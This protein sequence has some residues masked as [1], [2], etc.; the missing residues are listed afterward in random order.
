MA[1]VTGT[2]YDYDQWALYGGHEWSAEMIKPIIKE[3]E[4]N[5][6]AFVNDTESFLLYHG[7][8][9]RVNVANRPPSSPDFYEKYYSAVHSVLNLRK[10]SDLNGET[11][12]GVTSLMQFTV[13]TLANGEFKRESSSTA[14]L[15]SDTVS[16]KSGDGFGVNRRKL[17]IH[18]N[19]FATKLVFQNGKVVGI[20]YIKNGEEI[21]ANV[22]ND[23]IV[24]AGALNTPA[25]LMR[26]GIGNCTELS[27]LGIECRVDSASVGKHLQDHTIL[28]IWGRI[29]GNVSDT[30]YAGYK[31]KSAD[32]YTNMTLSS[33]ALEVDSFLMFFGRILFFLPEQ[34]SF[35]WDNTKK[36]FTLA[37]TLLRPR[38]M[39]RLRVPS[40][41][42]LAPPIIDH[43]YL[44][45]PDDFD[46]AYN[47]LRDLLQV[48]HELHEID[49]SVE[50]AYPTPD[51]LTDQ[52]RNKTIRNLATTLY[53]HSGTVR[54]GEALDGNLCVKGIGGLRVADAS[55]M[56]IVTSANTNAPSMM[57]GRKAADL[58]KKT[59]RCT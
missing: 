32:R 7:T 37:S 31:S 13:Q 11:Q 5:S 42:P 55:I 9:G 54:L 49:P 41:D 22:V 17:W 3:M 34:I 59:I 24:S 2:N 53:H 45:D 27:E 16:V 33:G 4:N 35:S 20:T 29:S 25:F 28:P 15:S 44:C 47:A 57:I 38:S 23:V 21:T 56:P 43:C 19:S 6:M 50:L 12:E 52:H 46:W 18:S 48:M 10:N 58:I 14:Y 30:I 39:G 51:L 36:P 1:Y 8:S 40:K 26:N